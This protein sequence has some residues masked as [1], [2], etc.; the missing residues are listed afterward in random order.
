VRLWTLHPEYLDQRGLVALWRE[1]LL[2]QAVLA[3]GTRGYTCHP[4]LIRF[5]QTPEPLAFIASYL[6]AV[7]AEAT[8]R[9]Y[10]FDAARIG[11][12]QAEGFITVTAGQLG[13]EA[14]HLRKKLEARAP[15]WLEEIRLPEQPR[16]HPLFRVVGGGVEAWEKL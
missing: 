10:C 2:A 1:A 12:G 14:G 3:G 8:C 13:Y 7:Q 4:Q 9:G 6:R 15:L 11:S 16:P 5:R